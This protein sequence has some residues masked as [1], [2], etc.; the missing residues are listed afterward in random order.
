MSEHDKYELLLYVLSVCIALFGLT[1]AFGRGN[2]P[3]V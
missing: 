2:K 1:V 3:R